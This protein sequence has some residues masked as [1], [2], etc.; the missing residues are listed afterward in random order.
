LSRV[1]IGKRPA[2]SDT[3]VGPNLLFGI[4]IR[5]E[6]SLTPYIEGKFILTDRDDFVIGVGLRF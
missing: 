1:S 6:S 3:D 5:T 4:A 2:S